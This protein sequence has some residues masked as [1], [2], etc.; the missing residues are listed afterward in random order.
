MTAFSEYRKK[1]EELMRDRRRIFTE[2]VWMTSYKYMEIHVH[3]TLAMAEVGR[4]ER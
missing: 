4:K 2:G 3:S 1:R